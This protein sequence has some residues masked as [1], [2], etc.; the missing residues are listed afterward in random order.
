MNK[1]KLLKSS[2]KWEKIDNYLKSLKTIKQN[3]L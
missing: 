3:L 2:N 1:T